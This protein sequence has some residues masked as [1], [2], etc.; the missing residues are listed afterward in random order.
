MKQPTIPPKFTIKGKPYIHCQPAKFLMN[1]TMVYDI[2]MRGDV[3]AVEVE[4]GILTV[5]KVEDIDG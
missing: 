4:T 1:S 5:V 2:V 3:F